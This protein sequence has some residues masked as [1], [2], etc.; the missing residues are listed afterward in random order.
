MCW[1]PSAFQGR[2]EHPPGTLTDDVVHQGSGLGGAVVVDYAEHGRAF[3]TRAATRVYSVTINRSLGK[4]RPPRF[5]KRPSRGRSTGLEH[6][7]AVLWTPEHVERWRQTGEKPS[8]VLVWTPVQVGEFLDHAEP[9]RLY[10]LFHLIA[11]RGLRRGEAVGQDWAG[12]DFAKA[13]MTV[14]KAIIQDG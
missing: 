2:G 7:S 1:L 8:G 4:V 13:R 10:A 5:A 12:V 3:P 9:D 11:F 6:C 14:S